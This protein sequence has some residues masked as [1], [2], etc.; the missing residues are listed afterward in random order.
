MSEERIAKATTTV[1]APVTKVWDAF[2][3]P[4]TIK[5]YMFGTDVA[6]DWKKGSA[7]TWKGEFQGKKYEDK[8]TILEIEPERKLRYTH[9][10]NLSPGE[11]HTVT[12]ELTPRGKKTQVTLLQDNNAT[13]EA[14]Q[15]SQKNWEMMLA[16]LKK[17][18][19]SGNDHGR[20]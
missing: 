8:G 4:Q 14:R 16:G 1:D 5:Q 12:V 2:V 11:E 15:H 20:V 10:S 3:N 17:I 13:E 6:S 7:I 18:L 9:S 19:E